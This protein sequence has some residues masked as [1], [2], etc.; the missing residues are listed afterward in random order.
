MMNFLTRMFS[1]KAEQRDKQPTSWDLL[2]TLGLPSVSGQMVSPALVEGL[3]SAYAATQIIADTVSTLPLIVYRVQDEERTG[4]P[5][6]PVQRLF[7]QAPNPQQTPAEFI[8]TMQANCLL[9]GAAYAEIIRNGQ[10]APVEL[11]PLHPGQVAMERI[12]GTRRI[13]FHVSDEVG[14][15][16][17]LPGEVLALKDR[18]DD[19]FTPRSRLDRTR[20]A[21]GAVLATEQFA[22][23]TW[24][25]GA[26]PSGIVSHPEQIGPDAAKT[27][28]ESLQALYGG[29]DNA[30]RV[31]VIEEGMSWQAVHTTPHYA[32]LSEARRLAVA[33]VSRIFNVPLPLLGDLSDANYSNLVEVRRQFATGGVQPWLNR[34][35][36]AILRDL[37]SEE[38][39]ASHAVE[40]DMDLLL[41]GDHLTRLQAYRIGREIGLY[42][43][44]DLRRFEGMNPRND[45]EAEAFLSPM[46]M[47]SEQ[48][49]AP[50]EGE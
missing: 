38:A 7:R 22:A 42:N 1:P 13:R 15:R 8:A 17:L 2:Q 50:R 4:D 24:R 39:Q 27:L 29:S 33:E 20:E 34:W 18:W 16:R 25:N 48:T 47:N 43:A 23:A 30:G 3:S 45:T 41:R 5:R 49:G 35:E 11:W 26:R 10:G 6:H 21:L 9:H 46:N 28:R 32:E 37:F 12:P 14:T 31:A 40:F 44:N 36:Q 19:P